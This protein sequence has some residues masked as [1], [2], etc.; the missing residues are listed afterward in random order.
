M[1]Q[2]GSAIPPVTEQTVARWA[3]AWLSEVHAFHTDSDEDLLGRLD[4]LALTELLV[5]CEARFGLWLGDGFTLDVLATV[6]SLAEHVASVAIRG[7]DRLWFRSVPGTPVGPDLMNDLTR[8]LGPAGVVARTAADEMALGIGRGESNRTS[9]SEPLSA[10]RPISSGSG[11]VLAIGAAADA[12]R[13]FVA[14]LDDATAALEAI[15]VWYPMATNS[16]VGV[17]HPQAVASGL[18]DGHL[19]HAACLQLLAELPGSHDAVY[20]GLGYAYRHEP[21]RRFDLRGR[22]EAYRVYE[23]VV[24]GSDV[25][26]GQMWDALRD[27]TDRQLAA[28]AEGS[29]VEAHDGFT[30]GMSRKLEWQWAEGRDKVPFASLND[31]GNTFV[32]ADAG[33]FCLG[34]GVDRLAGIGLLG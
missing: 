33:S 19:A 18:T 5:A 28:L 14:R 24:T 3:V 7:S 32:A 16:A 30:P 21:S 31:H 27:L 12:I 15:P 1:T 4:S 26:R 20:A 6:G 2:P 13:R 17:D 25:F 11:S 8:R 23:V 9:S 10:Q 29:W 34:I 22:L